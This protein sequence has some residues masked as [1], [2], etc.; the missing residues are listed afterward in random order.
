MLLWLW[1]WYTC[2]HK[3]YHLVGRNMSGTLRVV[4]AEKGLWRRTALPPHR[5]VSWPSILL[6][7][8]E[9]SKHS[10]QFHLQPLGLCMLGEKRDLPENRH[11]F[12]YAV[13]FPAWWKSASLSAQSHP[14]KEDSQRQPSVRGMDAHV[15]SATASSQTRPWDGSRAGT[16]CRLLSCGC[17]QIAFHVSVYGKAWHEKLPWFCGRLNWL[18]I[19]P[20]PATD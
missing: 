18:W 13:T 9:K 12:D 15:Y 20:G 8:K 1:K 3:L 16:G 7:W 4:V 6:K 14:W 11:L 5:E 10:S 2:S 17:T 19:Y